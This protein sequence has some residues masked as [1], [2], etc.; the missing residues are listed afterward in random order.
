VPVL[1]TAGRTT[2]VDLNREYGAQHL[3]QNAVALPNGRV[4]GPRA[5]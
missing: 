3:S 1:L 2:V 4:V 5:D